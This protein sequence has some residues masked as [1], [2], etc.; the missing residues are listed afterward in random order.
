VLFGAV[1]TITLVTSRCNVAGAALDQRR[2]QRHEFAGRREDRGIGGDR[3]TSL[4][5]AFDGVAPDFMSVPERTV[6]A[7]R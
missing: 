6:L 4:V 7:E 2:L 5:G 1:A 3:V